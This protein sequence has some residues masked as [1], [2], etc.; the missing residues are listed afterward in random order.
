MWAERIE[1]GASEL[2]EVMKT[3]IL[4]LVLGGGYKRVLQM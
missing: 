4:Y 1:R 3:Q 2:T